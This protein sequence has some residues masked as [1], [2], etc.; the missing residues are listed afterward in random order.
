MGFPRQQ[1]RLVV[2]DGLHVRLPLATYCRAKGSGVAQATD[3]A[4]MRAAC[5]ICG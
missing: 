3:K 2:G 1:R 5:A 4:Q